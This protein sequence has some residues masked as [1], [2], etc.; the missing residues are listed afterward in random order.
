MYDAGYIVASNRFCWNGTCLYCMVT[1]VLPN[2]PDAVR[3]KA[4]EIY[5][6]PGLT[7]V[8][9]GGEFCLPTRLAS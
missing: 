3:A 2:S 8:K 7:V 4:C 9:L 6:T 5:P 1:V